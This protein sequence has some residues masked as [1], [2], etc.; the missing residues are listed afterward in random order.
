V[1]VV[2]AAIGTNHYFHMASQLEKRGV[3]E[4]IFTGYPRF[5]L[6][7]VHVSDSRIRTYPWIQT[8]YM[9]NGRY[10]LGGERLARFLCHL[11]NRTLDRFVAGKMSGCDVLVGQSNCS[12]WSGRQIQASGGIY[13]VDRPCAHIQVQDRLL[14]EEY[15]RHGLPYSGIDPRII[16]RE[17]LEYST[18]DAILV[19]STFAYQSFVD[20]GFEAKKLMKIPYGVDTRQFSP[21]GEARF[22]EFTVLFVGN[23][24]IQKGVPNLLAAASK[25]KS[26]RFVFAGSISQEVAG[27][28]Q[29]AKERAKVEVLGHRPQSEIRSLMSRSHVLVLPSIQEGFGMVIAESLAC[30]L[31]VIASSN[32]GGPDLFEDGQ[33]GYLV[34][35]SDSER[36]AE[37]IQCLVDRPQVWSQMAQNALEQTK[38]LGDWDRYGDLLLSEL[39]SLIERKGGGQP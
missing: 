6:R 17:Q 13:V 3:L 24:S 35:P 1:K 29:V 27:Q 19:A 31:P 36:L 28:I 7:N 22:G 21:T 25:L 30:G 8:L 14:R 9:A 2:V 26:V 39:K 32:S 20:M 38:K 18:A 11:A 12:L 23:A 5:K 37:S 34:P 16:K 33:C 10:R 4:T 15:A